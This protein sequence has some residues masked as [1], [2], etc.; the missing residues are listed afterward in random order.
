MKKISSNCHLCCGQNLVSFL[1]KLL[2][3]ICE[4]Y[5]QCLSLSKSFSS[6]EYFISLPF[7][8]WPVSPLNIELICIKFALTGKTLQEMIENMKIPFSSE[9]KDSN[10]NITLLITGSLY[11]W[12]MSPKN[13]VIFHSVTYRLLGCFFLKFE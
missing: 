9:N 1:V 12:I 2:C 3:C 6:Y 8:Y 5:Q 13:P 7:V 10:K 4:K 11:L